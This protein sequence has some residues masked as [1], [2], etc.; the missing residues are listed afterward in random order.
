MTEDIA[1]RHAP[2]FIKTRPNRGGWR[3][4]SGRVESAN[5]NFIIFMHCNP[6]QD[7]WKSWLALEC[8]FGYSIIARFEHH[9]SHPGLHCHSHCGRSGI[10]IGASSM[11]N[12]SRTPKA[13]NDHRRINSWTESGFWEA[14]KRFFRISD[15]K[16]TLL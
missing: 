1:P 10:E 4:R 6:A 12:L 16:G 8:S 15:P 3:W 14:S 5:N 2:I 7:N 9:G 11:D 13:Q